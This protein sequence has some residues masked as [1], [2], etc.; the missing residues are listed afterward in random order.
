M[1]KQ[2]ARERQERLGW[3]AYD[4]LAEEGTSALGPFGSRNEAVDDAAESMLGFNKADEEVREC[5]QFEVA[6]M[7][8]E[9]IRLSDYILDIDEWSA[10]AEERASDEHQEQADDPKIIFDFKD[11]EESE[12][13]EAVQHAVDIW[14]LRNRRQFRNPLLTVVGEPCKVRMAHGRRRP[15]GWVEVGRITES[16]RRKVARNEGLR[17]NGSEKA[18]KVLAEWA[19]PDTAPVKG[20]N[21]TVTLWAGGKQVTAKHGEQIVNDACEG[22]TAMSVLMY[23]RLYTHG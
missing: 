13:L 7:R 4:P 10:K 18:L 6:R 3:Y 9:T 22:I 19:D 14:E 21:G 17:W 12:I 11:G 23:D 1:S 16:L 15:H 5:L 2:Q 20:E 8:Q